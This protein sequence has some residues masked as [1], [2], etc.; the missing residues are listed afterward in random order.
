MKCETRQYRQYAEKNNK[1]FHLKLRGKTRQMAE[2]KLSINFSFDEKNKKLKL[3]L[4]G[5][6]RKFFK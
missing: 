2:N 4:E 1:T 5:K 6:V 3:C